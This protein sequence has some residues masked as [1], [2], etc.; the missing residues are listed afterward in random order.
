MG[1]LQ[2]EWSVGKLYQACESPDTPVSEGQQD[3]PQSAE[4]TRHVQS[5]TRTP[6]VSLSHKY[7]WQLQHKEPKSSTLRK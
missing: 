3:T 2:G 1:T 6:E 5:D 7:S 4:H